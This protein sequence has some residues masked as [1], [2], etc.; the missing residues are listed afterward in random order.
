MDHSNFKHFANIS[1]LNTGVAIEQHAL[2]R[3]IENAK[4]VKTR[5]SP[6]QYQHAPVRLCA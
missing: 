3:L 1:L 2:M 6:T 5:I 4:W